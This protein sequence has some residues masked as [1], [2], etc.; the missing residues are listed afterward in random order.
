MPA[1]ALG[2]SRPWSVGRR[3][4]ISSGELLLPED[5]PELDRRV[6]PRCYEKATDAER[7]YI[8]GMADLGDGS[9]PSAGTAAHMHATQNDLSV[10]RAGLIEKGR[11][12]S[13]VGSVLWLES[14]EFVE[15]MAEQAPSSEHPSE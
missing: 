7:I 5:V 13:P 14:S 2:P 4:H 8:A 9:Y 3:G 15:F 10:R 6:L 1:A 11:I 12:E